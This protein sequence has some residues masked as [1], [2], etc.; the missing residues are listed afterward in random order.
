MSLATKNKKGFSLLELLLAIIVLSIGLLALFRA[1][2]FSLHY[3]RQAYFQSA[4]SIN[5]N[6]LAESLT[7][8]EALTNS[9]P[10]ITAEI[11]KWQKANT[12]LLPDRK[13]ELFLNG[14]DYAFTLKW[15]PVSLN[16]LRKT[17]PYFVS[18]LYVSG[19]L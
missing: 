6:A 3:N 8:C 5:L 12:A 9:Q 15:K 4:A 10:C 19:I 1:Q 17:S 13:T 18:T 7:T 16:T 14:N 2:L 11:K